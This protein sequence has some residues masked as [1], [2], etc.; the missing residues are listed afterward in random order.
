MKGLVPATLLCCMCCQHFD[1]SGVASAEARAGWPNAPHHKTMAAGRAFYALHVADLAAPGWPSQFLQYELFVAS[2]G[3][4][5]ANIRQV[6]DDIPH[7]RVLAYT[8]W[9]WA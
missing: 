2:L 8:D 5:I 1:E 7:A 9:S 4:S 3:F 6:K